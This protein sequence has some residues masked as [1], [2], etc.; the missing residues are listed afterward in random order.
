VLRQIKAAADALEA[1]Y[2]KLHPGK[3]DLTT[4]ALLVEDAARVIT[5]LGEWRL[6]YRERRLVIPAD[7]VARPPGR[8]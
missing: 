3:A 7:R 5:D 2:E 6:T 8:R 1:I 4:A